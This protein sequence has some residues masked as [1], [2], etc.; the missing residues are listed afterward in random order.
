MGRRHNSVTSEWYRNKTGRGISL[1]IRFICDNKRDDI[2]H[3]TFQHKGEKQLFDV[4]KLYMA[5]RTGTHE[6]QLLQLLYTSESDHWSTKTGSGSAGSQDIP[7]ENHF[8]GETR[9]R[10]KCQA[11]ALAMSYDPCRRT[12]LITAVNY[13]E[14]GFFVFFTEATADHNSST[15]A[16]SLKKNLTL[17]LFVNYAYIHLY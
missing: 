8:N 7:P 13:K 16:L 4:P 12:H 11:H 9:D 1:K 15:V 5:Q 17:F 2:H 14:E 6:W 10:A 3:S